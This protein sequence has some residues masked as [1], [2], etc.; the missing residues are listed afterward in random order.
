MAEWRTG[1]KVGRTLYA[2]DELI[3]LMDTRELAA[4]VA[5]AVN[6]R[7]GRGEITQHL[8]VI[9]GA[10]EEILMRTANEEDR[11]RAKAII[12]VV[13]RIEQILAEQ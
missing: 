6:E 12:T 4:E 7:V 13:R 11:H 1:R 9:N 2:G 8:S 3:G 10:A 5:A